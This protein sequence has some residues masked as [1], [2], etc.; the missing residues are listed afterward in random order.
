M[1]NGSQPGNALTDLSEVS[2]LPGDTVLLSA[3]FDP[4]GFDTEALGAAGFR[5]PAELKKA[6]RKRQ[7][8][9]LA[10]RLLASMACARLGLGGEPLQRTEGGLPVWPDGS[11]GSISHT[12]GRVACIVTRASH[13]R[14]GV[15]IERWLK[16]SD[17]E[18]TA[19]LFLTSA[20]FAHLETLPVEE[21]RFLASLSFSAKETLYKALYPT[22]Q[23]FFGF[24][25]AEVV[26]RPGQHTLDLV[27][28]S[29]LHPDLPSGRRF[30]VRYHRDSDWVMTWLA[31]EAVRS[32]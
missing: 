5:V 24:D 17:V 22:V 9:F 23:R 14:V 21:A 16:A 6:V 8:E 13:V 12:Q 15:D 27:L 1:D 30:Q 10:G 29:D 7:V 18:A 25:C 4:E 31:E 3:R 26:G 19:K 11:I 20:E 32:L 28:T 2:G